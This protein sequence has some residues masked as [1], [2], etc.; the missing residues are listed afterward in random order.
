LATS[1]RDERP[2]AAFSTTRSRPE[3]LAH[4]FSQ[5]ARHR[6]VGPPAENGTTIDG[7]VLDG[8]SAA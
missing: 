4:G 1:S 5:V 7:L 8:K 3:R 6:S 2:A